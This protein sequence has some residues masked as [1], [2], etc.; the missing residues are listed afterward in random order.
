MCSAEHAPESRIAVR[1]VRPV[2]PCPHNDRIHAKPPP[3]MV[4]EGL[5]WRASLWLGGVMDG[6]DIAVARRAGR[7]AVVQ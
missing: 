5:E 2:P 3:T 7:R 4:S 6:P 1:R